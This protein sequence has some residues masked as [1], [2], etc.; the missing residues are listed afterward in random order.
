MYDFNDRIQ[1]G[2]PF[3]LTDGLVT[4]SNII[5]PYSSFYEAKDFYQV[6]LDL[7]DTGLIDE[8]ERL[9]LDEEHSGLPHV[10]PWKIGK[11]SIRATSL[12]KPRTNGIKEE[13]GNYGLYDVRV[14]TACM[15]GN[16]A[17]NNQLLIVCISSIEDLTIDDVVSDDSSLVPEYDW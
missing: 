2:V 16:A 10:N 15:D 14:K 17:I 9:F 5:T 11:Y 12:V 13:I 3:S 1:H 8:I 7:P 4:D 6:T